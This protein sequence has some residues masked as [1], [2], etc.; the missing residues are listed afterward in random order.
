M[1][2]PWQAAVI[3]LFLFNVALAIIV[4][5]IL[6]RTVHA[7]EAT[8]Q[9]SGTPASQAQQ[10]ATLLGESLPSV[11]VL[12]WPEGPFMLVM[13]EVGCGA[14]RVL[15]ADVDRH[16]RDLLRSG[17]AMLFIIDNT[18]RG[19]GRLTAHFST[20]VDTE[21]STF[22]ALGISES[23]V[24]MYVDSEHRVVASSHPNSARDLLFVSKNLL[25]VDHHEMSSALH[26]HNERKD[27]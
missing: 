8:A 20:F 25:N 4:L 13:M 17:V 6:R 19:L 2:T 16:K 11:N 9:M 23:P 1:T 3:L 7:L 24:A 10:E 14:C 15:A 12:T 27:Q 5:G 21:R 18:E 26:V 22:D